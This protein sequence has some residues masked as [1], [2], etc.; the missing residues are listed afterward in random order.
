MRV[1]RWLIGFSIASA[2]CADIPGPLDTA[3]LCALD[4]TVASEMPSTTINDEYEIVTRILPGGF[5]GIT[6]VDLFLTQPELAETLRE[7]ARR[8]GSCPDRHVS[9]I[10][11][12]LIQH[13]DAHKVKYDWVELRRW[14]EQLSLLGGWN[15]AGIEPTRNKV[16][17]TFPTQDKLDA[18]RVKARGLSVP[19]DAFDLSVLVISPT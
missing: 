6:T 15:S 16:A 11:L 3:E 17:F 8:L 9:T 4:A 10:T 12:F 18:F 7:S 2:G 14:Q 1:V 19:S 5:A 13:N